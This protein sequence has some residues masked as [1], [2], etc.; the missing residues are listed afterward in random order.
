M[1]RILFIQ[2]FWFEFLGTMILSSLLK[3]HGHS[4]DLL[5]ED[6]PD[7]IA[8]YV[9]RS[10]VDIVGAYTVSGTHNWV[11]RTFETIKKKHCV[12]TIA[13]GPHPTFF[14]DFI[15][16]T[17]VDAICIGEGEGALV[18]LA[19]AVDRKESL[20]SIRNI[21]I[22]DDG[23]IIRNSLRPLISDLN[24]LPVPDR[25]LYYRK[26]PI[27][28]KSPNKHF[29]TGRGCPFNCNFCSNRAY[30]SLYQGLGAMVRQPD[31][32]K[33]CEEILLVKKNYPLK[34]VRFDDE[35]F[36][37][38]QAW[39]IE[40]LERYRREVKLP[41]SC[42]IRA[43]IASPES[44]E[45]MKRAGCYIAYFGIESGNDYIRNQILGKNITR[46]QIIETAAMLR[47]NKIRIGTFNMV[48]M[49]GETVANVWETI[50]LNQIIRSDYPW[51]SII[52]PYPG[53]ELEMYARKIGVLDTDYDVDSLNQSYFNDTVLKNPDSNALVILQ[54][55]FYIAVRYPRLEKLIRWITRQNPRNK[56]IQFVFNLTYAWR[57]SKTYKMPFLE[58]ARRALLW[59]KNY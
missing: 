5:I 18:E 16:N 49:P 25:D 12:L 23:R 32:G 24:I 34:A 8:D 47:K 57:Y 20:N 51:C 17:S 1:A 45:A 7:I 27:L 35:V 13:G 50:H 21:W 15:E 54:K 22:S 37:L 4:V 53:T 26:Y 28:A 46:Q 9:D 11:S 14:P 19:D 29:I 52:Q 2:N 59:K 48:G 6:Q 36:L 33:I 58:L 41:F 3:Q 38:D 55:L 10:R 30:K 42:L 44:I 31:P 40:F 39:L 43:D 56:L